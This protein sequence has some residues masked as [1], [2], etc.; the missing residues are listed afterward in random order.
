V[1]AADSDISSP[2]HHLHTSPLT[3]TQPDADTWKETKDRGPCLKT[4]S[5]NHK[6][7]E[8]QIKASHAIIQAGKHN[9]VLNL[10]VKRIVSEEPACT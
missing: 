5:E 10:I 6:E 4:R 7:K 8:F 9:S 1:K 2:C 3:K